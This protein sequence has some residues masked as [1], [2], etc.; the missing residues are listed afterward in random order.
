MKQLGALT[1]PL[2][3]ITPDDLY[4]LIK[5][6]IAEGG[7]LEFKGTLPADNKVREPWLD[8]QDKIGNHAKAKLIKEIVAFANSYGGH[9]FVGIDETE[10]EPHRAAAINPIPRVAS[11]AGRMQQVIRD[12]IDPPLPGFDCE[13]IV[14]DDKGGGILVIQVPPSRLAP[15]RSNEDNHAYRRHGERSERMTMREIQ[16]L[17]LLRYRADDDLHTNID[18]HHAALLHEYETT[19]LH[20]PVGVQCVAVPVG[21]RFH[22]AR[23]GAY[24][25]LL[26][27]VRQ[28]PAIM[29]NGHEH[30]PTSTVDSFRMQTKLRGIRFHGHKK[31]AVQRHDAYANGTVNTAYVLGVE[32]ST[33]K[34]ELFISDALGALV[35]ALITAHR[36]RTFHGEPFA[37]YACSVQI[38]CYEGARLADR[39]WGGKTYGNVADTPL[40]LP[41]YTFG[42]VDGL[43]DLI[44][45]F[46]RDLLNHTGE[47]PGDLDVTIDPA[48]LAVAIGGR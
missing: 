48:E 15:H 43:P 46:F 8:G 37:E 5:A 36:H 9:V 34:P 33:D 14:T 44:A 20:R 23:I 26:P 12:C 22:V 41:T 19:S 27:I 18:T 3:Q 29:I 35:T 42:P 25:E 7:A 10:D 16:D 17:T 24:A 2:Q 11:L 32:E 40:R 28:Y 6:D 31:I 4:D 21:T 39:R 47:D 13:G 1:K 30:V 38:A 45:T